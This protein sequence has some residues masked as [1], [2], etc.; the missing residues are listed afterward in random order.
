VS[1]GN[2][3]TNYRQPLSVAIGNNLL[4]DSTYAYQ[5]I[6]SNANILIGHTITASG[7]TYKDILIGNRI[8]SANS[9]GGQSILL[10]QKITSTSAYGQVVAFNTTAT[11]TPSKPGFYCDSF[12][13]ATGGYYMTWSP[14]S[15]SP[16][17]N[18]YLVSVYLSASDLRLKKDIANTSLGL[19]FVKKLRP[20]E[21]RWK[22]RISQVVLEEQYEKVHGEAAEGHR[23]SG[24]E[25]VRLHQGFIAQEVKEVLDSLGVDSAIYFRNNDPSHI[26]HDVQGIKTEELFAPLVKAI[27]EQDS[28]I[29]SC[30]ATIADLQSQVASLKTDMDAIK[31]ALNLQT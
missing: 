17:E 19:D 9:A 15:A 5:S 29:Q 22:D 30:N 20:V 13:S 11:L 21:F 31:R 26:L 7:P 23:R 25:G 1:I 6:E 4:N 12:G 18:K 28:Q 8:A 2:T 3:I 10:G 24:G 14:Y 16:A 27:Q